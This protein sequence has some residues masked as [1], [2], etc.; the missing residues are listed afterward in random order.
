MSSKSITLLLQKS[1]ELKNVFKK[2][3]GPFGKKVKN[4]LKKPYGSSGKT[5][6]SWEVPSKS[7]MVIL[8]IFF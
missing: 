3:Y 1:K 5:V 2:R 8:E 6:K 4:V 7:V